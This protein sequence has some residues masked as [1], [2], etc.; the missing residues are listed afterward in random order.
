MGRMGHGR[1]HRISRDPRCMESCRDAIGLAAESRLIQNQKHGGLSTDAEA[2]CEGRIDMFMD[3]SQLATQLNDP[4]IEQWVRPDP[5][6]AF[7][8]EC[9]PRPAIRFHHQRQLSDQREVPIRV[10]GRTHAMTLNP[11][12]SLTTM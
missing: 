3:S 12:E 5:E 8:A 11:P 4:R 7:V 6:I 2:L 1:A 9:F 10:D